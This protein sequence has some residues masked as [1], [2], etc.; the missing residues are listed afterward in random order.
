MEKWDSIEEFYF[1]VILAD[2]Y[3]GAG[4]KASKQGIVLT[5]VQCNTSL[6]E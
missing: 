2:W 4:V 3:T 1:T 6:T 5:T